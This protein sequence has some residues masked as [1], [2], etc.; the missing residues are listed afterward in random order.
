MVVTVLAYNKR[1][2]LH[3]QC[4][5]VYCKFVSRRPGICTEYDGV[6]DA[7]VTSFL[8]YFKFEFILCFLC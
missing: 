2:D 3:Q 5:T 7:P 8:N 4:Y 6:I 1:V